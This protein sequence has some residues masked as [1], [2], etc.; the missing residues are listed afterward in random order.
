[1]IPR[2]APLAICV[3]LLFC[4]QAIQAGTRLE[5]APSLTLSEKYST[6]VNLDEEDEQEAWISSVSPGLTFSWLGKRFSSS[7]TYAPS[8]VY[9][10]HD[11]SNSTIRHKGIFNTQLKPSKYVDVSLRDTFTW[12]DQALSDQNAT[13]DGRDGRGI[14]LIDQETDFEDTYYTN[15]ASAEIDVSP[16]RSTDFGVSYRNYLREEREPYVSHTASGYNEYRF[17]AKDKVRAGYSYR[18][19]DSRY[20]GT[21]DSQ[22]HSPSLEL[23]YWFTDHVGLENTGSYTRTTYSGTNGTDQDDFQEVSGSSRLVREFSRHFTGSLVYSHTY[24]YSDEEGEGDYHIYNPAVGI[25]W[26]ITQNSYLRTD[27]GYFYRDVVDEDESSRDDESGLTADGE[28][29]TAWRVKRGSLSL[30]GST[31]YDEDYQGAEN[32]GFSVYYQAEATADYQLTEHLGLFAG[33]DVRQ[34]D[35]LDQEPERTDRRQTYNAGVRYSL[36]RWLSLSLRNSYRQL[37]SD[38][39]EREYKEYRSTLSLSFAP[40]PYRID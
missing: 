5:V 23:D 27:V 16:W 13:R 4:A 7:I 28:I 11:E 34:D 2:I 22:R 37:D 40:R 24:H 39:E 19:I 1:M 36:T 18:Q 12:T 29:G 6:N 31:G 35:Y 32:L 21:D 26:D 8:F 17:G 15:T 10:D 33:A 9:Y 3:V 30:T 20:E 38:D 25:D 14:G